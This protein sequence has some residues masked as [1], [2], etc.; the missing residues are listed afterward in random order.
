[1]RCA[2]DG[3]IYRV[4]GG[5]A[6][7]FSTPESWGI[8]GWPA[9]I[10]QPCDA[11]NSCAR[12]PN[13][14]PWKEGTVVRCVDGGAIYKMVGGELRWFSK[15]AYG[16]A[17]SP[18]FTVNAATCDIIN[19]CARGPNVCPWPEGS[20]VRCADDGSIYKLEAGV[21]R[22]YSRTAYGQAGRPA[23]TNKPC[24]VIR[25]CTRGPDM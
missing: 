4:V 21:L 12:G 2:A 9:Y 14:C 10:D 22:W 7:W 11:I 23:F 17:G 15:E 3:A 19:T 25:T 5:A 18:A 20:V 1:M 13:V 6:R 8:A 24:A 16:E